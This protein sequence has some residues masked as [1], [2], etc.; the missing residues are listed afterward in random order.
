MIN[1]IAVKFHT[2]KVFGHQP[3]RYIGAKYYKTELRFQFLT[4]CL[5]GFFDISFC[6][7]LNSYGWADAKNGSDYLEFWQGFPNIY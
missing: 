5:E 7:F 2:V 1:I 6:A 3:F 4:W